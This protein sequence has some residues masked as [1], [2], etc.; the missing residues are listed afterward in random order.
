MAYGWAAG[1]AE[2]E[3]CAS[4]YRQILHQCIN[5]AVVAMSPYMKPL[6]LSMEGVI[7]REEEE[8]LLL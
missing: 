1:P 4:K 5:F 2:S 6:M 8:L 7:L 3:I